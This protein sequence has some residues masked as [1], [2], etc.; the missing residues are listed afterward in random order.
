MTIDWLIAGGFMCGLL[1]GGAARFGRLCTM[2]AVEDALAGHDHRGLKAWGLAIAMAIAATQLLD[3]AGL[4][5]LAQSPYASTRVHLLGTVAGGI[6]FGLGMTLVGTCSFGLLVRTGGGDLR[7]AV[8]A[9][10][11]G[12]LAIAVT[13]GTLAPL[14]EPLLAI[15]NV[16]MTPAGGPAIDDVLRGRLGSTLAA[17]VISAALLALVML[18]V[19]DARLR[20]RPRLLGSAVVMGLAVA[21]AWLVTSRAADRM[22]IDR[23]ESLSFVAPVGRAL[24]Q[25][26]MDAFR[27]AGFGVATAA[28]VIAAS[29]AI[30]LA[31]GEFRWEAF[32]DPIEMRRHLG[33]GALMGVGGVLAQGCTIGQGL[34]AASTLAVT[35]PVFLASLMIGAKLGLLHLIEGR[36]LWRLGR[37]E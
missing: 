35:A 8:S 34:S 15:G 28:G 14:R 12:V 2:S 17:G 37:P 5:D 26:M 13:A 36:S 33:G 23:I 10:M 4:I 19:F 3:V 25:F 24:G 21:L 22:L 32:D 7:A 30:A 27:N 29:A 6:V 11:V 9:L 1:A 20:S 16:D 31:N 18:A